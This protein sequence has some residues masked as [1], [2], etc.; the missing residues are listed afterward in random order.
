M[1]VFQ[2]S[3]FLLVIVI[4]SSSLNWGWSTARIAFVLVCVFILLGINTTEQTIKSVS[5]KLVVLI[6]FSITIGTAVTNSGLS[7][8]FGQFIALLNLPNYMTPAIFMILCTIVTQFVHNNACASI[9]FPLAAGVATAL[10]IN[11]KPLAVAV[12]I[13]S[14]AVF[15]SPIGYECNLMIQGPGGYRFIHYVIFGL[16]LCLI[17][18]VIGS[19]LIPLIWPVQ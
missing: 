8:A 7:T 5:V 14:S 18:I 1:F 19:I 2:Y 9:F 16:P 15:A 10:N 4:L 12:L 17:Y 11:I 6:G 13:G 3:F